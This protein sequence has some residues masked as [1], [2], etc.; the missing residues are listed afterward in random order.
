MRFWELIGVAVV[1]PLALALVAFVLARAL[2]YPVKVS[3]L[4]ALLR[5]EPCAILECV[6]E[7]TAR[8]FH[9][10][11]IKT[12][13]AWGQRF[14]FVCSEEYAGSGLEPSSADDNID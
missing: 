8:G 6:F 10:W 9:F 12:R 5:R 3:A 11:S 13:L 2:L 14:C 1:S 7:A 4:F